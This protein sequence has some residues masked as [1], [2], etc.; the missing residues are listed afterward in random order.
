[1]T[2][3]IELSDGAEFGPCMLALPSDRWRNF[4]LCFVLE[5]CTGSEAVRKVGF[6]KPDSTTETQAKQGYRLLG[7]DRV[8]SA[9][10]ELG[11]QYLGSLV[12][13]SIK[14]LNDV[15]TDPKARHADRVKAAAAVLDR[16]LP[17][18]TLVDVKHH[19]IVELDHTKAAIEALRYLKSLQVP[20]SV[21]IEKFGH[22][23]LPRYEQ[24]IDAEDLQ[25]K[26]VT[27][28]IEAREV[29]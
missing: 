4:V 5:G 15:L 18:Q 11:R 22:S 10:L 25:A 19:H 13:T 21:L 26:A 27:K 3:A 28:L 8:Q 24:M 23:G 1:M 14:T 12:G 6:C 17:S 9:I 29:A 20:R 7:D 2:A 16:T